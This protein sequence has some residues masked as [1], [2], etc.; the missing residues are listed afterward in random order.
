MKKEEIIHE[1]SELLIDYSMR[2]RQM[3]H[4]EENGFGPIW[5]RENAKR[6]KEA[7]QA[8]MLMVD[9]HYGNK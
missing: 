5:H 3:E 4:W 2:F 7:L 8:A 1:L 6:K 9:M